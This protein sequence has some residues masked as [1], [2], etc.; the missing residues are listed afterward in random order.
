MG[1]ATGAGRLLCFIDRKRA[2]NLRPRE[3]D[4]G[5]EFSFFSGSTMTGNVDQ[6]ERN[7]GLIGV[8]KGEVAAC[9]WVLPPLQ[10]DQVRVRVDYS[11][12]SPGTELHFVHD[13]HTNKATY[14]LTLGYMSA[15]TVV[16]AGSDVTGR[17]IGDRVLSRNWH[18]AFQNTTV[19]RTHLLPDGIDGIDACPSVLLAVS[20]RSIRS[21]Q[22][23]FGDSCVVFGL[24]LIGLYAAHLAKLTGAYPVIGVDPVAKRRQIAS[25]LGVDH[26]IDPTVSDVSSQIK[27]LTG[28]EGAAVSIDATGSAAVMAKIPSM[29]AAYGRIAVLGGI[30]GAVAMDLYTHVQKWNQTIV[31]CGTAWPRDFP[32]DETRNLETLIA[33]IHAGRVTPKPAITHVVPWRRGPEMYEALVKD[34]ESTLGVVF[35]WRE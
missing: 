1:K 17:K 12:I 25:V 16:G 24:G 29:T 2:R 11:M 14:P 7:Q 18:F 33:M 22:M 30:H 9:E 23:R 4:Q 19:D 27:E 26:V 5:T 32:H 8:R 13:N 28:N 21:T 3:Y 6:I 31:G 10:K 15:G 34:K 20:L 35:D